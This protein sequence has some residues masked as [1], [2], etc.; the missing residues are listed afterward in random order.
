MERKMSKMCVVIPCFNE[1]ERLKR[2]EF[3]DFLQKVLEID[4]CFVNDGST[5]HSL[6]VLQ[7]MKQAMPERVDIISYQDNQGKAEAVR[8]GMLHAAVTGCYSAIAFADADLATP[9]SE[10]RRLW[11]IFR[12]RPGVLLVMGSRI[13]RMG[14]MLSRKWYR[15]IFGRVFANIVSVLFHLNAH[16]TQCG[17]KVFAPAVI[18]IA[19]S[20]PFFSHWLFD[21]EILLRIRNRYADYNNLI[22]EVPLNVWQE[23]GNSKIRFSHLLRMPWQLLKI[24]M[25]YHRR[26][27]SEV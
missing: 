11:N 22:W 13:R 14:V 12:Q 26:A 1:E 18:D 16:D 25:H 20:R 7:A 24:Y 27:S 10:V 15:H 21:I 2:G 3:I 19:F 6:E 5:D 23:Q 4:F 8:R 9:L 17:A